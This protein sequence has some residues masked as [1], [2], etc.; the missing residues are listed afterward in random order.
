MYR[1]KKLY[2]TYI[3]EQNEYILID[4]EDC[5]SKLSDPKY[6]LNYIMKQFD[7]NIKE[8]DIAE[9]I[10]T[11]PPTITRIIKKGIKQLTE[12][13]QNKGWNTETSYRIWSDSI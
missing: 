12:C 8:K 9:S 13:L 2:A 4:L 3:E 10:K 5:M 1:S 7:C 6:D 11:S